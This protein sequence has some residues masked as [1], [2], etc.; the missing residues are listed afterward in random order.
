M[1]PFLK[2]LYCDFTPYYSNKRKKQ[3]K[4]ECLKAY[5]QYYSNA[6]RCCFQYDE[7][8]S[9]L[10]LPIAFTFDNVA[11]YESTLYI[12]MLYEIPK[13]VRKNRNIDD[14]GFDEFLEEWS[15]YKK[16]DELNQT[17]NPHVLLSKS[18]FQMS[19]E[20]KGRLLE[21][22]KSVTFMVTDKTSTEEIKETAGQ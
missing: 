9:I 18:C 7:A 3:I 20:K 1:F 13:S 19:Y 2:N 14:Y 17:T 16:I 22:K 6:N 21:G 8:M 5:I 4:S 10:P 15:Y 11:L 12:D